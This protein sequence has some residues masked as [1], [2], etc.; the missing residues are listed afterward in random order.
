MLD[1]SGAVKVVGETGSGQEALA[2]TQTLE[3]DVL[4]LD[5]EMPGMSGY[6]VA[7]HLNEA[8]A[9][10]QVLALSGY[11]EK[12][13][14]LG[15]FASGAVGYL[16]KDEAPE[17]LVTAITEVASGQKGWIS[18]RIAEKLGVPV[19]SQ[20]RNT[21][22]ALTRLELEILQCIKDERSDA[23]IRAALHIDQTVLL[24]NIQSIVAKLGIHSRF[25]IVLRALQEGLLP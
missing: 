19:R 3:P 6:E 2:L 8:D 14:I 5:V 11:N 16:T 22:P 25:E 9:P 15:M 24:E 12:H 7:R 10:V 23:E 1:R 13:H 21:V 18:P 20:G 4:L 17:Q